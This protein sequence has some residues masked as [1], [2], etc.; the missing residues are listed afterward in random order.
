[1]NW[2]LFALE[3]FGLIV[4]LMIVASILWAVALSS[5]EKDRMSNSI[6]LAIAL[7]EAKKGVTQYE[8]K[9]DSESE[10]RDIGNFK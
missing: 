9:V 10:R 7:Q 8:T 1:M 2:Y 6:N 4:L 5:L 3:L